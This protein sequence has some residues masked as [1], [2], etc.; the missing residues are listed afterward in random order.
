M[1]VHMSE[2]IEKLKNSNNE[3]REIVNNS[4]DGI[5]IIDK[6][7]KFIYVN[8]AFSPILGFSK[9]EFLQKTFV[10][11]VIDTQQDIFN[12]FV[13]KNITN[14]YQSEIQV[15]CQRKD[16]QKVYLQITIS[17][18]LNKKFFVINARDI[19]KQISDDEIQDSYVIS[20]HTDYEGTITKVSK[21]Y[22]SLSG[23]SKE[24]LIGK[25]YNL[26]AHQ[27][28][29]QNIYDDLWTTVKNGQQWSGKLK[30]TKKD[31][32]FFWVNVKIKPMYNKYG[33]IT[34]FTSLMFDI[35][36]E[37]LLKDDKKAL[38][39]QRNEAQD[40][41][42]QKD[43]ILV[44][45]SK[46]AIMAETLQMVSHEWR[47][48]LNI[49]S[50]QAQKVELDL[51]MGSGLNEEELIK[52][53]NG[54]KQ[55]ADELSH[56]IEDFQ[57]FV[58]LKSEK[59][60][61]NPS[62]IIK[63]AVK[64]F[65]NDPQSEDI[66]FLKDTMDTPDF[67]TYS[68]EL[69]TILVNILINSKEAILKNKT[70]LGVIKL[71]EYHIDNTIYFEVSDNGGGISEEIKEKIFEPYFST[72]EVQHG[73]GLGLYMCKTIIEMHFK[74]NIEV[75]NHNTGATFIIMLPMK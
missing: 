37:L 17:L 6:N 52:T 53:L 40:E 59:K 46:L 4:W 71:K 51:S 60:H 42:K 16:S 58:S 62:E 10:S 20:C 68:N 50:I 48:P 74:G 18:M 41:I 38:E 75:K 33:D 69:A 31:K 67:E 24:D 27:D 45:Q 11:L 35:T 2:D 73:V 64:I 57:S 23:F 19:T 56:T 72:K 15:V 21:A 44:Q 8:N 55:T 39:V 1:V 3:L 49:I 14:K 32:S 43:Q 47:Q 13:E 30:K 25:S 5:G 7:T 54:I 63:K 70:K 12:N 61:A 22:S 9:E 28:M 26:M 66:D 29:Q 34:G 65:K 36:N